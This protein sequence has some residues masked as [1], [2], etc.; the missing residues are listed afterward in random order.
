M[1]RAAA[2]T[3]ALIAVLSGAASVAAGERTPI[4]ARTGVSTVGQGCATGGTPTGPTRGTATLSWQARQV[5]TVVAIAL[6]GAAPNTTYRVDLSQFV[7]G[8]DACWFGNIGEPTTDASG[9]LRYRVSLTGMVVDTYRI[10]LWL[11]PPSGGDPLFGG[12]IDT[13]PA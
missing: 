1:R 4:Q 10:E 12:A 2:A 7:S 13:P 9:N 6:N 3:V 11:T 8:P 5:R